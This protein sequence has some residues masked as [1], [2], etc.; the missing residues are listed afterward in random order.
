MLT[1]GGNF[2]HFPPLWPKYVFEDIYANPF[3][4]AVLS[5]ILGPKP[6]LTFLAM[7]SVRFLKIILRSRP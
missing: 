2:L 4:A 5:N 3:A 7:N 6:E 1:V